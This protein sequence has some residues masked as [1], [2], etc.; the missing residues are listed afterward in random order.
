MSFTGSTEVGRTLMRQ[1]DEHLLRVS[2]ELGGNAPFLVCD[3]ADLDVAVE[4]A[5]V[6][7]MRNMGESCVA[8]NRYHV[9]TSV[10]GEFARRLADRFGALRLGRGTEDGV[11]V[12]P[13]IDSDQQRK[14]AELV[15]DATGKG[16]TPLVGGSA[17]GG[18][19]HFYSPTVL[20]GVPN[21]ADMLRTEIFGPVA[22]IYEFA[23]LDEG[24]AAANDSHWGLVAYL[25][26]S[27]V[28]NALRLTERLEA[29]MVGVNRGL[30]STPA[31][32]FGGIKESGIGREGG[33][34]GIEEYVETKYAALNP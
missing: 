21:S 9:H 19:G 17:P 12:G 27:N 4:Q 8:A 3:D 18:V 33:F 24:I 7:K 10:A 31:A 1:A 34:E 20:T 13:L 6:A 2:M 28:E 26:T 23:E 14:V 5:M 15:D 29:G 32:P 22:P 25:F 30:V 11:D 16:A